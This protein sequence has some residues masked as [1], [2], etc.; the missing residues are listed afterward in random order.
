MEKKNVSCLILG[1]Y[2][3]NN[4]LVHRVEY[5][6]KELIKYRQLKKF[7]IQSIYQGKKKFTLNIFLNLKNFNNMNKYYMQLFNNEKILN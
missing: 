7:T 4:P 3:A 6:N 1:S 2:P 5:K